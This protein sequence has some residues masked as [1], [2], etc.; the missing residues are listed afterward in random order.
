MK[1]I[2]ASYSK[3]G[4]KTLNAALTRLGYNVF[5]ILENFWFYDKEWIEILN[6][7]RGSSKAYKRMFENVDAVCDVPAYHYWKD[8]HQTF[9]HAKVCFVQSSGAH[10]C[11]GMRYCF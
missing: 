4:T 9:P 3:C 11:V 5:D 1:V 7:G 2:V 10:F 8:I 6:S